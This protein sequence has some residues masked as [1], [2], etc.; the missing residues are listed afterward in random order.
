MSVFLAGRDGRT[1]RDGRDGRAGRAGR[2]VCSDNI[3][4]LLDD[5]LS[6]LLLDILYLRQGFW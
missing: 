3:S 5:S 6:K 1:E 4:V 2:V